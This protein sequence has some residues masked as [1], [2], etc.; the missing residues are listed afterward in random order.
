MSGERTFLQPVLGPVERLVYRGLRL[1][2][3][4]EQSWRAYARSLLAFS[5]AS[6]VL[7]YVLQRVQGLLPLNPDGVGA[8]GPD[9]ALNTAVS[10][11]T[12]TDWQNYLGEQTMSHLTQM[13]GL[14]TQNFL[15]AG[16]GLAVAVALIRGLSRRRADTVGNFWVDLTR[17]VV[18]VLLPLSVLRRPGRLHPS[19]GPVV[20]AAAVRDRSG[21][22]R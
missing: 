9:L 22:L 13:A 14:A 1:R 12:N 16:V 2:P 10:F 18:F 4:R 8:V 19:G 11:V 7:L 3:D 5:L 6:V 17:G 20:S 21:R 15:S